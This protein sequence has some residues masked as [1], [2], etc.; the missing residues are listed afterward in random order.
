MK[1]SINPSSRQTINLSNE[2]TIN[3]Q[4]NRK[5]KE[6]KN[7]QPTITLNE[8]RQQP[9]NH[10][11][12]QIITKN[13]TSHKQPINHPTNQPIKQHIQQLNQV[14]RP[15]KQAKN[16]WN[17]QG[18]DQPLKQTTKQPTTNRHKAMYQSKQQSIKQKSTT[19]PI[20]QTI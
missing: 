3:T 6:K 12:N 4:T 20:A 14:E 11:M 2:Q 7:I 18:H 19:K 5:K 1:E 17:K 15:C 13:N 16:R 10:T 9:T 8:A